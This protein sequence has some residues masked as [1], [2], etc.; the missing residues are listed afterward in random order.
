MFLKS[1]IEFAA[2]FLDVG[3]DR[4][5]GAPYVGNNQREPFFP[6]ITKS[7]T[8]KNRYS[9]ICKKIQKLVIRG[10]WIDLKEQTVSSCSIAFEAMS[11][12]ESPFKQYMYCMLCSTSCDELLLL[13]SKK[14]S[15]I[16][17]C[18]SFSF[19]DITYSVPAVSNPAE[20]TMGIVHR[21]LINSADADSIFPHSAACSYLNKRFKEVM[22][23][24][25]YTCAET[26]AV[27]R[28]FGTE[29]ALRNQY[30]RRADIARKNPSYEVFVH[31]QNKYYLS[32]DMEHGAIEI[33]KSQGN[34]PMHIGE[35]N[36]ACDQ[37][38]R[39]APQTHKL[40][41]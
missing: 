33:F 9:E 2:D 37:C 24:K 26:K 29:V 17:T 8:V 10:D 6:P 36:F 20:N 3:V 35:F 30:Q 22:S 41:V 1:S 23:E 5:D 7:L 19:D 34:N 18:A 27:Y 15:G 21:Y 14:N 16:T 38:K 4:Y 39:S 12:T 28:E 32:I 13:L 11:A 40:V 31:Q 25:A